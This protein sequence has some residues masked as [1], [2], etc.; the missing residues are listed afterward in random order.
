MHEVFDLG[1]TGRRVLAIVGRHRIV[2][3]E[4]GRVGR[5][6]DLGSGLHVLATSREALRIEGECVYRVPPLEVPSE[7]WE[8]PSDVLGRSAVELLVA[9][10]RELDWD[11]SPDSD[12][13]AA[14]AAPPRLGSNRSPRAW[15]IVSRC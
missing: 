3:P 11:F 1:S 7:H 2:G 15:M 5:I 4:A 6:F 9:R 10:M 13:L 8:E 12:G 14:I